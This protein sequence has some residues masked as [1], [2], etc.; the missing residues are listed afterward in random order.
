MLNMIVRTSYCRKPNDF[1][2]NGDV[3]KL[4]FVLNEHYENKHSIS[5][6]VFYFLKNLQA[7]VQQ[8]LLIQSN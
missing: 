7:R 1:S 4:N 6:N 3:I 8:P 5:R 2:P